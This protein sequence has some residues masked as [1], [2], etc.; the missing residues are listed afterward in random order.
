MAMIRM[1]NELKIRAYFARMV[2]YVSGDAIK[3]CH[4][5]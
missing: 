2:F 4:T 1:A 3:R 5:G